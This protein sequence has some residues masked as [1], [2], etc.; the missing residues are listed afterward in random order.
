MVILPKK[1][2]QFLY[3]CIKTGFFPKKSPQHHSTF[4]R[5]AFQSRNNS[6]CLY[7]PL[8]NNHPQTN[9]TTPKPI[10]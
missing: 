1:P 3:T 5:I 10:G 8:P 7:P 9:P 4:W 2:G 6:R